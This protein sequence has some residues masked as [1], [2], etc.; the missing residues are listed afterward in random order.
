[1]SG[2]EEDVALPF[3]RRKQKNLAYFQKYR[4]EIFDYFANFEPRHCELVVTPGHEDVDLIDSGQSI[5]RHLAQEYA[6]SEVQTFIKENPSDKPILTMELPYV[7]ESAATRFAMKYVR[8]SLSKSTVTPDSF[9]GYYRGKVVPSVIF[10]GCGLGYHIEQLTSQAD[11]I[12]AVVFEPDAERF[13]LSLFTV[14]WEEICARFRGKGRAISF[15]IATNSSEENLRRVLGSKMAEMVPLYPYLSYYYNHLANVDLFRIAKGLEKDL[16]VVGTNWGAYDFELRGTRNVCQNLRSGGK[17]I[18]PYQLPESQIPVAIVG[19]GPSIDSRIEALKSNRDNLVVISAGTGLRALLSHGVRPDFHVELDA[20]YMIY[21]ML[22]DI[23]EQHGLEG[24]TLLCTASVNPL[25]P[26]MF[27]NARF[28]FSSDYYIPALLGLEKD[29]VP[30]CTPTCT[31]A[32]VALAFAYGFRNLFLFGTDYGYQDKSQHHSKYSVYGQES[33]TEFASRFQKETA[34]GTEARPKFETEGVNETTVITQ[35]DYFT[36]KR[37]LETYLSDRKNQGL[38]F[39]VRNCSDGALIEGAE[40]IS[41][42][43]FSEQMSEVSDTARQTLLS[44]VDS[45]SMDLPDYDTKQIF[46]AVAREVEETSQVFA[47]VLKNNRLS[48]R[49]DL[50]VVCNQIRDYLGRVGPRSGR[51]SPVTVQLMGW[52]IMKGTIQR[53]LQM[54]LCHGLAHRD[55]DLQPFLNHW[56]GTFKEFLEHL[57]EHFSKVMLS[58]AKPEDDPWVTRRLMDPEADIL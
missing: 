21:E 11:V 35:G 44:S 47:S 30:G 56:S 42:A 34:S 3:I 22:N 50:I 17:Y 48:G 14:D 29:S 4:P 52:Q 43:D 57:P 2:N 6:K 18:Q 32:A 25:V 16:P 24:I 37:T 55:D 36:A 45:C 33:K 12:D 53:F 40:W 13:A 28:Y 10:L 41:S 39:T 54:G 49:K 1:M 19:S 58:D 46:A 27:E 51:R 20:D 31:N 8:E 15:C 9:E 23:K 26:P 38:S 7:R 5:Y